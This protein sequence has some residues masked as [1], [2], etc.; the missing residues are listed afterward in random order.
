[1][2]AAFHAERISWRFVI[3]L[4]LIHSIQR[5][6]NA[7]SPD[8]ESLNSHIIDEDDDEDEDAEAVFVIISSTD[9][10]TSCH[11]IKGYESYHHRLAP[12]LLLEQ[13]LIAL[14]SNEEDN[15]EREATRLTATPS[16]FPSSPS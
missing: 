15:E 4:N 11:C 3:Y 5:I 12:L 8:Y 6:L 2:P 14:L 13:R 1:M 16:A 9:G 10:T 7:I